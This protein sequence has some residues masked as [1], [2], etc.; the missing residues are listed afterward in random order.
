MGELEQ[1]LG[2]VQVPQ[3]ML[4]ELDELGSFRKLIVRQGRRIRM[5]GPGRRARQP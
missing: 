2:A 4:A 5:A 1:P 3:A